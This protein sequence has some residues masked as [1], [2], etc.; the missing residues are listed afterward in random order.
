ME[1]V[2]R[3]DQNPFTRTVEPSHVRVYQTTQLDGPAEDGRIV[4]QVRV[5]A[6]NEWD[7]IAREPPGG[8][9]HG[10]GHRDVQQPNIVNQNMSAKLSDARHVQT[11]L[12]VVRNWRA[13]GVKCQVLRLVN[14]Q[15][16]QRVDSQRQ[17]RWSVAQ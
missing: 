16:R 8:Q 1:R 14:N 7:A 10:S 2:A 3:W 17:I 5:E 15:I 4:A 11:H 12:I 13:H 9:A 6:P